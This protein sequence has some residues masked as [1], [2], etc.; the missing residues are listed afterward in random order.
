LMDEDLEVHQH[1]A[2][3]PATTLMKISDSLPGLGIVAAVLGVVI[4]MQSIDGPAAEI[5]HNVAAAL[6]GTFLGILLCY[7]FV[8]PVAT[9]LEHFVEDDAR[10]LICIKTGLLAVY[11]GF[12]PAIAIEF[13]RRVIPGEVRPD[14]EE[15]EQYC[16]SAG[17]RPDAQAEAA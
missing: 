7:G 10:Y 15:T 12:A 13:A 4:T 16:R 8:G 6:V 3:K 2:I 1:D 11:K 17:Q 9:H 5:G 14:F